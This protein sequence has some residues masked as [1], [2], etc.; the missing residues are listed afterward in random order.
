MIRS[1]AYR[2]VAAGL[3]LASAAAIAQAAPV[4]QIDAT[5][6]GGP[7]DAGLTNV[8]FSLTYEDTDGNHLFSLPELLA[9][10]PV[11]N[12]SNFFEQLIGLPDL[13]GLVGTGGGEWVFRDSMPDD[14]GQVL[15]PDWHAP[16]GMFTPY[17]S[18]PF[19][20]SVPEPGTWALSVLSLAALGFARRNAGR[21]NTA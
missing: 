8:G 11:F 14:F 18:D 1:T 4:Y 20:G 7:P 17:T 21:R 13:A 9:F 16:A 12:G 2:T 3:L 19:A 10:T 6:D 15:A 5:T